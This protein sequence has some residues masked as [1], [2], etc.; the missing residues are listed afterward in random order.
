MFLELSFAHKVTLMV[1]GS[2]LTLFGLLY[3]LIKN[4]DLPSSHREVALRKREALKKQYLKN[5]KFHENLSDKQKKERHSSAKQKKER[6]EHRK[7][8][9]KLLGM[10]ASVNKDGL[11]NAHENNHKCGG[12][13]GSIVTIS[14]KNSRNL[15]FYRMNSS[16]ILTSGN[17]SGKDN[18][19]TGNRIAINQDSFQSHFQSHTKKRNW[20]K[21]HLIN[22]FKNVKNLSL[23]K[24]NKRRR[25]L[26]NKVTQQI[27]SETSNNFE[28]QE[29]NCLNSLHR[30][31]DGEI[32][33]NITRTSNCIGTQTD[34]KDFEANDKLS[35]LAISQSYNQTRK[36]SISS[37]KV[38]IFL[39]KIFLITKHNHCNLVYQSAAQ[40]RHPIF[41][42]HHLRSSI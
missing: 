19:N 40:L 6:L 3:C 24:E 9:G 31:D 14:S 5:M 39:V 4:A 15:T 17:D 32:E 11:I 42:H 8:F 38:V 26:Y 18:I 35:E 33:R 1:I 20:I 22:N 41:G 2:V 29:H 28:L 21:K 30:L 10:Y 36:N 27:L 12:K 13:D 37:V 34:E 7:R 16:E 25:Q 23:S